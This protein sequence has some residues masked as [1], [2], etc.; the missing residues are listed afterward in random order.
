MGIFL[1][2]ITLVAFVL[3]FYGIGLRYLGFLPLSFFLALLL[4]YTSLISLKIETGKILEK[5]GFFIAWIVILLGLSWILHFLWLGTTV[6]IIWLISIN[7]VLWLVSYITDYQDGKIAFQVGYYF[8]IFSLLIYAS[9]KVSTTDFVKLFSMLR[10]LHLGF[11]AFIT[12]IIWNWKTIE[13]YLWYKVFFLAV[14]AIVFIILQT[15][16]DIYLGFL[17]NSLFLSATFLAVWCLSQKKPLTTR[18][19]KDISLRRILAGEKILEHQKETQKPLLEQIYYFLEDVP[20]WT[21]YALEIINI[22]LIGGLIITFV[23]NI[24]AGISQVHQ[25]MFWLTIISYISN[26]FL[27]KKIWY[28]SNFQKLFVFWVINFVIYASLFSFVWLNFAKLALRGII[29]N[30]FSSMLIFP[31]SKMRLSYLL[32]RRDY[33]FRIINI[34]IAMLINIVLL[35]KSPIDWQLVF[36]L[37]FVYLGFQGMLLFSAFKILP[38]KS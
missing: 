13:K 34:F 7:L 31:S 25:V 27:L 20:K 37:V 10:G 2:F 35:S 24:T 29:W 16:N 28:T 14:G 5:Y 33:L 4:Y 11:C 6:L 8:S 26:V 3:F 30:I 1:L 19:K 18:Q 9:L 23:N 12:F 32:Q 17:I 38:G 21:K 15:I 36:S 22:C